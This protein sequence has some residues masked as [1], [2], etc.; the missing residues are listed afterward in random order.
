MVRRR[1]TPRQRTGPI[2]LPNVV[3]PQD[4]LVP[5][6]SDFYVTPSD[7]ADPRDCDRYPSSPFCG[8][9]PFDT[10]PLGLGP[11]IVADECNIGIEFEPTLLF[12]RLPAFQL[13]YRKPGCRQYEEPPTPDPDKPGDFPTRGLEDLPIDDDE[14]IDFFVTWEDIRVGWREFN[15]GSWWDGQIG[16]ATHRKSYEF[17]GAGYTDR[18]FP[19]AR[20]QGRFTR[21]VDDVYEDNG[22]YPEDR[23]TRV[24][25]YIADYRTSTYQT[26]KYIR[27]AGGNNNPDYY[28]GGAM[29]AR[30]VY[31]RV[32]HDFSS[33]FY[34]ETTRRKNDGTPWEFFTLTKWPTIHWVNKPFK[35][36]PPP[37]KKPKRKCCMS[38]CRPPN[39]NQNNELL[40]LILEELKK[41]KEVVGYEDFPVSVPKSLIEPSEEFPGNLS[42]FQGETTLK[43]IPQFIKWTNE[44]IHAVLGQFHQTIEIEDTD[45]AQKGEQSATVVL[46]NIS[47]ALTELIGLVIDLQVTNAALVN[48]T[49]R[50][51]LEAG[52]TKQ[53]AI[54]ALW[55]A[56]ANSEFLGYE[57]KEKTVDVPFLFSLP[58]D[59]STDDLAALLTDSKEKVK[60]WEMK[61]ETDLNDKLA[62]IE[63][64][65]AIIKSVFSRKIDLK[66]D[67]KSQLKDIIQGSL[68]LLNDGPRDKSGVPTKGA[69]FDTFLH[70]VETGFTN[71][72]GAT[73]TEKPYGRPF[74]QRPYIR[75]IGNQ[76]DSNKG[77]T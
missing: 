70:S 40:R 37:P 71:T 32:K 50:S 45:L 75:E 29:L 58:K 72:P 46:P 56:K 27:R 17:I 67:V 38:C 69:D 49:T 9:I 30:A 26:S 52:L 42:Q 19:Y 23:K 76:A 22:W 10:A 43:T 34:R 36:P 59:D 15:F 77:Q 62:S 44:Q 13:V 60:V 18:Y 54:K 55:Y 20:F 53:Q 7:P 74:E 4:S 21:L 31:G 73:E 47:E 3:P 14:I 48:I 39:Q 8:G 6:V 28:M 41:I 1:K 35:R 25:T 64:A 11:S 51:L 2:D 57:G 63:V 24:I 68:T 66:G 33:S 61:Q 16:H 5:L 65:A 12:N